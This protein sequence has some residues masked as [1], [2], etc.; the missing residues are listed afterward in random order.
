MKNPLN[1]TRRHAWHERHDFGGA[2]M[3]GMAFLPLFS[4]QKDTHATHATMPALLL[5]SLFFG[6][7]IYSNTPKLGGLTA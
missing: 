7:G 5:I 1:K 4:R 6:G 2:G 3:S